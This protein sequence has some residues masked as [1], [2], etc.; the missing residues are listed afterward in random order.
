MTDPG[1]MPEAH[2]DFVAWDGD[3]FRRWAAEVGPDTERVVDGILRSRRV[4]QRSYRSCRALM[5][6]A[7]GRGAALLEET[8]AKALIYSPRPSYKTVREIAAA[9]AGQAPADGLGHALVR[10]AG[11]Y[12]SLEGGE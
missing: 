8:C 12:G 10:G 11:Y 2:R 3:R 4:E 1:H 5:S 7:Q 9:L 6:I